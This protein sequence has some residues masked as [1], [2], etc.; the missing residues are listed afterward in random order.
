M[1]Q[2][3]GQVGSVKKV[4][5][6]GKGIKCRVKACKYLRERD[7]PLDRVNYV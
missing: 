5:E 6:G 2:K 3:G 4:G 1:E 7:K